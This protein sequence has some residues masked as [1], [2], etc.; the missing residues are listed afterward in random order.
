LTLEA[1]EAARLD[2]LDL[3]FNSPNPR[4]KA[5][6]LTMGW[7]EVGA[8]GVLVRPKVKSLL[9]RR[10]G[11]PSVSGSATW[12]DPVITDRP[13][14]GLRTP[15]TP[16]YLG[17]RFRHPFAGYV[18]TGNAEGLAVLR[19]NRRNGRKELVVSDLF[20]P[21]AGKTLRQ[22]ARGTDADYLVGWFGSGAPERRHTRAAGMFQIPAVKALTIVAQPLRSDLDS[23]VSDLRNW[24]LALSDLE[25][26]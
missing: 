25:L 11:L 19:P 2:G 9:G 18:V 20:G 23:I 10:T 6:Y 13:P 12:N 17:W 1:V 3:I 22:A 24:D 16:Q 8:I 5:G 15:R 14:L 4:S 26:L 7:L 21:D